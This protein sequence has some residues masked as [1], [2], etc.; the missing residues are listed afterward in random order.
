M[1]S[2][3]RLRGTYSAI[4]PV[5]E[6]LN[7]LFFS[8]NLGKIV[9]SGRRFRD[10]LLFMECFPQVGSDE[11]LIPVSFPIHPRFPYWVYTSCDVTRK[12]CIVLYELYTI[13][14]SP[15]GHCADFI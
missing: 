4:I 9:P 14:Y 11:V 3:I 12:L 15:L 7:T 5:N 1:D 2:G 6:L 13:E 8:L 10:I